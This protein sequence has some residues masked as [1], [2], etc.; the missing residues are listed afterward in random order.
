MHEPMFSIIIPVYKV[1]KYLS[2]CLESVKDQ[3]FTDYEVI[4]IDDGSPDQCPNMCDCF[5]QMDSRCKVIHQTNKG[6]SGARNTGLEVATGRYIYFLDSDDTV[7]GDL[8]EKLDQEL[9]K[10]DVD[11]IGFSA[12]VV[13]LNGR[14]NLSTGAYTNKVEMGIEIARKR[15]PLSTVPLYCYRRTF[16]TEK[17]LLFKEKIFYEDILFTALVFLENPRIYYIDKPLYYYNKREESITMSRVKEKNYKD[18]VIICN[19]LIDTNKVGWSNNKKIA[20][21]NIM[22]TYILLSE[23]IY[24][25][26]DRNDRKK[27]SNVRWK[28]MKT[29]K[30]KR[31]EMGRINY[32]LACFPD[33]AYA[34]REARRKIKCRN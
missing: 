1:E 5:A 9:K 34:V 32:F 13:S 33:V 22:K 24:R 21:Q 15:V 2:R 10:H 3:T 29:V 14:S 18:I 31:K 20:F 12:N 27:L 8:L 4:L 6:L 16:L 25:M 23:E 28:L 7:A 30:I 26:L 19:M 17:H 11:I